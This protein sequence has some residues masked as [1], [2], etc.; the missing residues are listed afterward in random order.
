MFLHT[1][2]TK[3]KMRLFC[4]QDGEMM[5]IETAL[6]KNPLGVRG[7]LIQAWIST[8]DW[9]SPF[10]TLSRLSFWSLSL[11]LATG[12]AATSWIVV[13]IDLIEHISFSNRAIFHSL[14]SETIS[15]GDLYATEGLASV[16]GKIRRRTNAKKFFFLVSAPL[17]GS[18]GKLLFEMLA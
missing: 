16:K 4:E 11:S 10:V 1:N 5:E 7:L 18:S 9:L 3:C 17:V 12:I 2:H 6:Q 15:K 8:F 14:N 13:I